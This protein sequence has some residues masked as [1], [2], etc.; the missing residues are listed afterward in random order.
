M[1]LKPVAEALSRLLARDVKFAPDCVGKEVEMLARGLKGGEVLLLENLRFHPEEEKNDDNFAKQLAKLGE[2]FIQDAFGTVHRAHA[3]TVGIVKFIKIAAVGFLVEK[4]VE[5][6]SRVLDNPQR[7]LL[8]ILGGAKV[9]DKI[10][11]LENLVSKVD[12]L[13]IGGAMAYTFLKAK[14]LSVGKSRVE[15]ERLDDAKKILQA[16]MS[17]KVRILLPIDHIV[18]EEISP[19]AVGKTVSEVEIPEGKIGVDIGPASIER[20]APVINAARTIFWNGPLGIFEIKQFSRGTVEIA[21]LVARATLAGAVSIVGGG[22]SASAIK[23]AGVEKN[24]THISTG[25]GAS[26]EFMEGPE[27]PGL[28]AI[29]NK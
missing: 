22:D 29:K 18:V 14:G 27:L 24:I 6:L 23:K 21:Q 10:A 28:A 15:E 8:A 9:N 3:S 20:F 7:P 11:V 19:M 13:I 26:L 4:E 2:V 25:G 12:S 16:A 17:R 5:N 1:S